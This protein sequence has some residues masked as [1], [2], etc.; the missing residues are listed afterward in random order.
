M[1]DNEWVKNLLS[2]YTMSDMRERFVTQIIDGK[3][4]EWSE[5]TG[6]ADAPQSG[7]SM[8]LF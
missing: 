7:G 4:V 1:P 5:D 3:P 6:A 2:R 8:E